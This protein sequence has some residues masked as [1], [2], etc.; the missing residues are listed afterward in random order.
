MKRPS[1]VADQDG[2]LQ[3]LA[4][5]RARS[6]RRRWKQ[7]RRGGRRRWQQEQGGPSSGGSCREK[8]AATRAAAGAVAAGE[9]G[10]SGGWSGRSRRRPKKSF[11]FVTRLYVFISI[12]NYTHPARSLLRALHCNSQLY[13]AGTCVLPSYC[14][15]RDGDV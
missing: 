15:L 9:G 4:T 10:A 7:G 2:L 12:S 6:R 8:R 1:T 3:P 5:S 11:F 13:S 14:V